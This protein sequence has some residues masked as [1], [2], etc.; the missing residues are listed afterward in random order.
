MSKKSAE[1]NIVRKSAEGL[2]APSRLDFD[3]LRAAMS[4]KID[5]GDIFERRQFQRLKRDSKGGLPSRKSV[6][7]EAVAREMRQRGWTAYR[8]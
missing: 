7:R 3:R 2:P 5:T 1:P 6:I 8:L 4:G